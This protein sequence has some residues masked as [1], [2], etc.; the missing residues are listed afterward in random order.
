[1]SVD[2]EPHIICF[3]HC[4]NHVFVLK[5]PI[6]CPLCNQPLEQCEKFLPFSLPYPFSNAS[7]SPCSVVLR[8]AVGDFLSDFHNN[9]NLH[10]ALTDSQGAIVEFDSPGLLRTRNAD[11]K[12]WGQCL[13]ILSVPEAWFYHW[14]STIQRLIEEQGWQHR[15]YDD[16]KLNCY[17]FVLAFLRLLLYEPIATFIDNAETFSRQ[18]IVPKTTQAAKYITIYRR[19]K[20]FG[21]LSEPD[22]L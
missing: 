19:I 7:Q 9:T 8:P 12:L 5:V 22:L 13:L 17:S 16:E 11:R 2:D 1:M 21:I 4:S 6:R 18:L 15:I 14:D 10:I 3:K 20:Q